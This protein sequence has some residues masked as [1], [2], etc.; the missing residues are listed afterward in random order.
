[1]NCDRTGDNETFWYT[2]WFR[3][4]T[5]QP[6]E[7]DYEWCACILIDAPSAIL[8]QGWGDHLARCFSERRRTEL[9]LR[10]Q[11]EDYRAGLYDETNSPHIAHGYEATDEEL[12]W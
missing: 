11:T 10:S 1:M 12:G 6:E 4:T 9:F 8:A 3:D 7:Q 5:L 2:A